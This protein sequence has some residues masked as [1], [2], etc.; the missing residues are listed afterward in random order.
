MTIYDNR[1]PNS[2]DYGDLRK[3]DSQIRF[4]EDG[5]TNAVL[6]MKSFETLNLSSNP[7]RDG[8]SPT[9]GVVRFLF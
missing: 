7:T 2:I 9:C 3:D 1:V 6:I 8:H 5:D 4:A